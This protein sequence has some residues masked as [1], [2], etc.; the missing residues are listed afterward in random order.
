MSDPRLELLPEL[1]IV[2]GASRGIGR[3]IALDAA[4]TG[5]HVLCL[6][7]SRGCEETAAAIRAAGGGADALPVDLSDVAAA[8]RVIGAWL[9][10]RTF[11]R[12]G[13]ALTAGALGPSGSLGSTKLE[14]WDAAYRTNVL[15][16]LAVVKAALPRLLASRFGRLLFFAGGGA[17]YAY[18]LFPAYAA[19][20]TALVRVV[21]NLHEDLRDAGDFAV[22]ILAPGAVD[23]DMLARVRAAGGEVRTTVDIAEPVAFTRAFLSAPRC[24]FSGRFVHVRDP[25]PSLLEGTE[26]PPT[27]NHWKLRRVE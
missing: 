25:W 3:A 24:G 16:N 7:R 20:K 13:L 21:E 9:E 8:E 1:T 26:E 14:D 15:G 2:S 6:S 22:A 23:T 5:S 17:A 12:I 27:P 10:G 11:A 4:A 19:A 18:P